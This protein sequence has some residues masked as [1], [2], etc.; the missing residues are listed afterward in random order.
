MSPHS[1]NWAIELQWI[2]HKKQYVI[3]PYIEF[4]FLMIPVKRMIINATCACFNGAF[5]RSTQRFIRWKVY[6]GWQFS[7]PAVFPNRIDLSI[8]HIYFF[9]KM[10]CKL[11][12]ISRDKH[13]KRHFK[14]KNQFHYCK[15]CICGYLSFLE[16]FILAGTFP[17]NI[18]W[19]LLAGTLRIKLCKNGKYLTTFT[20]IRV[21]F[22]YE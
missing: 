7:L 18:F 14:M 3:N 10:W 21:S 13:N 1:T 8:F 12:L 20:C 5:K 17:G 15:K 9:C 4:I 2:V 16:M 22:M 19:A 11:F 6:S